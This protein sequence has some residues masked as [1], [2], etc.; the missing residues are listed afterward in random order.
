MFRQQSRRS[1]LPT[2]STAT[3]Q[4]G[5]NSMFKTVKPMI[6]AAILA[7]C[8][9]VWI[10]TA[11]YHRE[12]P[13]R[14][15]R[16][17]VTTCRQADFRTDTRSAPYAGQEVGF[18][19]VTQDALP[20]Q[21]RLL[22]SIRSFHDR[23]RRG[24]KLT[25]FAYFIAP[26]RSSMWD[27]DAIAR[28]YDPETGELGFGDQWCT[29]PLELRLWIKSELQATSKEAAQ[30]KAAAAKA[31]KKPVSRPQ[32]VSHKVVSYT[33]PSGHRVSVEFEAARR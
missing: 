5:F 8:L 21:L 31:P 33:D 22:H 9:A 14:P 11:I 27:P 19:S 23:P 12:H 26:G 28:G 7:V 10:G 25:C 1:S 24:T 30:Q 13:G 4:D 20:T 6:P 3:L 16:E 15:L 17:D 2:S 29:L 18:A 32:V